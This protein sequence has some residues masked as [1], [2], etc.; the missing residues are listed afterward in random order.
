MD[1]TCLELLLS[2]RATSRLTTLSLTPVE[3]PAVPSL[4]FALVSLAPGPTGS[5]LELPWD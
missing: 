5:W 4:T 3:T 2:L 1:P